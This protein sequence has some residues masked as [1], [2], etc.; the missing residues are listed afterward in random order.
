MSTLPTEDALKDESARRMWTLIYNPALKS[1]Y[2][3]KRDLEIT[4]YTSTD[5]LLMPYMDEGESQVK[6]ARR[7]AAFDV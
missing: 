4:H 6:L 3:A 7:P 1:I 5:Q 2:R